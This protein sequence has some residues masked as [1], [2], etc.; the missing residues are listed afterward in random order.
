MRI[1]N[2]VCDASFRKKAAGCAAVIYSDDFNV[3]V[4]VIYNNCKCKTSHKA[5]ILAVIYALE[6]VIQEQLLEN[7]VMLKIRTDSTTIVD[8]IENRLF[9]EWDKVSWRKENKAIRKHETRDWYKLAF[10]CKKIGLDRMNF[11]KTNSKVDNLHKIA[12]YFAKNARLMN[13]F[14][15]RYFKRLK[16]IS[17]HNYFDKNYDVEEIII[18][19]TRLDKSKSQLPWTKNQRGRE[20]IKM[21]DEIRVYK[22]GDVIKFEAK[23]K[24]FE[25]NQIILSFFTPTRTNDRCVYFE[26]AEDDKSLWSGK[27]IVTTLD[28]PGL[29]S[30][31]NLIILDKSDNITKGRNL[32]KGFADKLIFKI[33]NDAWNIESPALVDISIRE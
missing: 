24:D 25:A 3:E 16:S 19:E 27:Y 9:D 18:K 13:S 30:N 12:D 20:A 8:F 29:Y 1:I 32:L 21:S 22:P 31:F 2:L 26:P 4:D 14:K 5:E 10:I 15:Y 11:I 23:I 7:D 6:Y 17:I 33:E 28:E